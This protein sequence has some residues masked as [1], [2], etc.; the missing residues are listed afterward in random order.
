MTLPTFLVI[1]AMKA[2]TTTLYHHLRSHPDVFMSPVKEPDFF[3][4]E[5]AWGKGLDWYRALFDSA[6]AATA[7]GEASTTYSKHPQYQGVPERVASTLPDVRLV[8]VIRHPIE[9]I[10]SHHRQAVAEWG[11]A[12]PIGDAIAARPTAF[13]APSL[14]SLQI[15]RY[16]EHLPR[17]R[18]LVVTADDLA[19]RPADVLRQVFGFLNVDPAAPVAPDRRWNQGD[20]FRAEPGAVRA[21]RGSVAHRVAR[22]VLPASARRVAWRAASRRVEVPA[23]LSRLGDEDR[24][25]VLEQVLPD[26]ARLRTHLGADFHC[27]GLVE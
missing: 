20:G 1:G 25:R 6:G 5:K 27:W 13:I 12:E 3:V 16:L 19:E 9:R 23:G 18:L 4:A 21:L 7:I 22:A 11:R 14:Y 17:E 26:V 15:E 10:E 2:G 8:Y 24:A